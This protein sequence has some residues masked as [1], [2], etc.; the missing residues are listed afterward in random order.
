MLEL[1][2][3]P[4]DVILEQ[5]EKEPIVKFWEK[6]EDFPIQMV[7]PTLDDEAF[8]NKKMVTISPYISMKR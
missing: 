5:N 7:Y 8:V 6:I 2:G 4:L 3:A 1:N